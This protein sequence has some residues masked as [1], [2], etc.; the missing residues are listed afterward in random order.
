MK[1]NPRTWGPDHSGCVESLFLRGKCAKNLRIQ[2]ASWSC[3][4]S[5]WR[6]KKSFTLVSG[7][8]SS[9]PTWTR[10]AS[11]AASLF[12][13]HDAASQATTK[14]PL[15]SARAQ[16][17]THPARLWPEA[18][19]HMI[20]MFFQCGTFFA[21]AAPVLHQFNFRSLI[22]FLEFRKRIQDQVN[23]GGW[24]QRWGSLYG[25]NSGGRGC[26]ALDPLDPTPSAVDG[27]MHRGPELEFLAFWGCVYACGVRDS[28]L[29]PNHSLSVQ[30]RD[31][32]TAGQGLRSAAT[33]PSS[34]NG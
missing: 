12:K 13:A 31:A 2:E 15:T 4:G 5:D 21:P 11:C 32:E 6:C 23:P 30:C 24:I 19:C 14:R 16:R 3:L 22:L 7:T 29:S 26:K 20:R 27:P 10:T 17:T 9:G 25:R 8:W 33:S 1:L 34:A 18:G 28:C